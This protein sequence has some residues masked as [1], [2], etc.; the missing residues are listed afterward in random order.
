MSL[1]ECYWAFRFSNNIFYTTIFC[2][3]KI[4]YSA[5]C[6]NKKQ[7]VTAFHHLINIRVLHSILLFALH[8]NFISSGFQSTQDFPLGQRFLHSTFPAHQMRQ[9]ALIWYYAQNILESLKK[10]VVH[11]S[12]Q[13]VSRLRSEC[14]ASKKKVNTH[15]SCPLPRREP[16]FLGRPARPGHYTD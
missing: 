5:R 1:A 3:A 8:M 15:F 14:E 11:Y 7:S 9:Q 2:Q 4:S 16:K 12:A 13:V 10:S 6:N